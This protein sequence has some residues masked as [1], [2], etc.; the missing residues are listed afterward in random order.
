MITRK[1]LLWRR[2][3][4]ALGCLIL[5]GLLVLSMTVS[6][7]TQNQDYQSEIEEVRI[8]LEQ[9]QQQ[10]QQSQKER[11]V[12]AVELRRLD[13]NLGRLEMLAEEHQ[14][15]V[16][17][18][19][20]ALADIQRQL[21]VARRN[22]KEQRTL[23]AQSLRTAMIRGRQPLLRALLNQDELSRISRAMRYHWYHERQWNQQKDVLKAASD[24]YQ[25]ILE[26]RTRKLAEAEQSRRQL[27][28]RLEDVREQRVARAEKLNELEGSLAEGNK[29]IVF[30]QQEEDRLELLLR[31]LDRQ[32]VRPPVRLEEGGFGN[33]KGGLL[34]PANGGSVTARFNTPNAELGNIRWRGI[35]IATDEGA[36]I[37]AV[38]PGTV[39]F[40]EWLV[41]HGLTIIL[42]HGD[43]M[44][45]Y[46]N[47]RSLHKKVGS[48]VEAGEQLA[49]SGRSG[50]STKVG[51]YFLVR[52]N[53]KFVD[54][55]Q[56]LEEI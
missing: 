31:Q 38:H 13:I 32:E 21:R 29:R 11:R 15:Q 35:F 4:R 56:W 39:V 37:T 23:V 50:I 3:N 43:Y 53:D 30:L 42:R 28:V 10:Q 48:T 1:P 25:S 20:S 45:L 14:A 54:P 36:P 49:S 41:A 22:L 9:L 44:T 26:E 6:A 18:H 5:P 16:R 47:C 55:L 7:Q 34:W 33:Y 51:L 27:V 12:E 52:S 8:K 19:E 46:A 17:Q 40:A 2:L 24:R